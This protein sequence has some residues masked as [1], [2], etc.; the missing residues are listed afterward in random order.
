MYLQIHIARHILKNFNFLGDVSAGRSRHRRW[1]DGGLDDPL[2][3]LGGGGGGHEGDVSHNVGT[4]P[5][6][7][8]PPPPYFLFMT[9]LMRE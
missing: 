2:L 7:Q 5:T 1:F 8:G 4:V 6:S 9:L 3:V